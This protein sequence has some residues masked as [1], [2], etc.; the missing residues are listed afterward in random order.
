[1]TWREQ[2]GPVGVWRGGPMVDTALAREI[3]GLGFGTIWLG[4]SPA[5]DLEH[6]EELIAGT[7]R[8]VLATGIVNIWSSDAAELAASFHRIEGRYPGRLLLGIGTGH[9]E[10]TA[11]RVRPLDAMQR[12]LDVLDEG[13]VPVAKRVISALGPKMLVI[14]AERS[15]GTHPYLTIPSQTTEQ[16]TVLGPDALVAPEQTVVLETDEEE[17]RASARAFLAN[18]LRMVNYTTTMRRGGFS[19]ADLAD[20]GSDHLVDAI[21]AHGDAAAV[22]DSLRAHL[23]AGADHVCVQ[24]QPTSDPL[25][26][27]RSI[28][29][30]LQR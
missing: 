26:A 18:Y 27:Y 23:D 21:V 4:S 19:E 9:R 12:Y 25:P 5:S 22:A 16:R 14:A 28:A 29:Q 6:V 17:A 24:V 20:G 13:G 15:G 2:L 11:E 7:D 1:M 30:A 10:A 8:V 3:E